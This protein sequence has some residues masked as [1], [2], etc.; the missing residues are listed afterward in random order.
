[1]SN[2]PKSEKISI[3]KYTSSITQSGV[4]ENNN[5]FNIN[6][7]NCL[8]DYTSPDKNPDALIR[9]NFS[10]MSSFDNEN[11]NSFFDE[12][13]FNYHSCKNVKLNMNIVNNQFPLINDSKQ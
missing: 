4:D 10:L 12:I 8:Y 1:M 3:R 7:K 11:Y 6:N 5:T 9:K 2:S 13:K